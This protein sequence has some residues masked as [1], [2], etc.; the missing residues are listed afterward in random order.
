LL[1]GNLS[2]IDGNLRRTD[3][4]AETIDET[5]VSPVQKGIYRPTI[6]MATFWEAE[7]IELPTSQI[8]EAI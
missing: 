7:Q 6:N 1:R 5:S 2:E 4:D 8:R 3:T